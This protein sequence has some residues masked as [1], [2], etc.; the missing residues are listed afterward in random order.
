MRGMRAEGRSAEDILL[1]RLTNVS[2]LAS[3][4]LGSL[5]TSYFA[6]IVYSGYCCWLEQIKLCV[7]V[8]MYEFQE[9][10]FFCLCISPC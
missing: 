1:Q 8:Y 3:S 4:V 5:L 10:T 6:F 7:P 2:I 9:I